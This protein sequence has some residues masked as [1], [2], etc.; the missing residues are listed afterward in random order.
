MI[1]LVMIGLVGIECYDWISYMMIGLRDSTPCTDGWSSLVKLTPRS[2]VEQ[3]NCINVLFGDGVHGSGDLRTASREIRFFFPDTKFE[4]DYGLGSAR[5][6]LSQTV[7]PLLLKGLVTMSK[8][9]P[10]IPRPLDGPMASQG[11]DHTEL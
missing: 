10:Q 5:E 11:I 6:Y 3:T 4:A 1:G 8:E 7:S 9:K 2:S